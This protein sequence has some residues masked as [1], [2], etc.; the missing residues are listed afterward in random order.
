MTEFLKQSVQKN[1]DDAPGCFTFIST[2][3]ATLITG[4][5]RSSYQIQKMNGSK[6]T[7]LSIILPLKRIIGSSDSL[8]EI[9]GKHKRF[10]VTN[11]LP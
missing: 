8:R 7:P 2:V 10:A 6:I 3:V 5:T 11:N 4:Q 1:V 9:F